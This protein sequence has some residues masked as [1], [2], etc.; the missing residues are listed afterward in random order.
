M[1][2]TDMKLLPVETK[3]LPVKHPRGLFYD[4]LLG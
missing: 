1:S 4:V 2:N 3:S